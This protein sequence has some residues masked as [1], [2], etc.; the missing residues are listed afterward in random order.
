MKPSA[1]SLRLPIKGSQTFPIY[2]SAR[3]V[4]RDLLNGASKIKSVHPVK[5][6]IA[7]GWDL[8]K[9]LHT[10]REKMFLSLN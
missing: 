8:K 3:G 10:Y 2:F 7:T 9:N 5:L 4:P 6:V 1:V